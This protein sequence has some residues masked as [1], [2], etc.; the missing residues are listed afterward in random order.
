MKKFITAGC[1]FIRYEPN[2][3]G[4]W[5][6]TIASDLTDIYRNASVSQQYREQ[7]L[8]VLKGITL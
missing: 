8:S 1:D 3:E 7:I 6:K 4:N 5:F 2:K